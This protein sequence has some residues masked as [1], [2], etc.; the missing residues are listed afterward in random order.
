MPSAGAPQDTTL[1]RMLACLPSVNTILVLD[2]DDLASAAAHLAAQRDPQQ[3]H[4]SSSRAAP[5]TSGGAF[6]GAP[7]S[8]IRL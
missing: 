1:F 4:S 3:R 5:R 8:P 6:G 7:R 2:V